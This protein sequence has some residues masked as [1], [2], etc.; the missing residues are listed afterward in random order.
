M[1]RRKM[2][3]HIIGGKEKKSAPLGWRTLWLKSAA[4]YEKN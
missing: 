3:I 1:T 2:K 4:P